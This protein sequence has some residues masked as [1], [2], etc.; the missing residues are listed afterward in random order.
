[1]SG[2]GHVTGELRSPLAG[3][4]AGGGD[5]AS[6]PL[7]V[8]GPFLVLL[9]G[10]GVA[11]ETFG[12]SIWLAVLT[13]VV[14]ST[15][16]RLVMRWVTDGSGGTGLTEDEFGG[17]AART[18][19]AIT[20]IEFSL[21]FAVSVAALVTVL[22]DRLPAMRSDLAGIELRLVAALAISVLCGFLVNRG[23]RTVG[24][25]FGPAT[26][27]VLVLL[28]LMVAATLVRDGFRP[29]SLHLSAFR[30]DDLGF[31][32]GGYVRILAVMTGVEVFANLV[33]AYSGPAPERS[34]KAFQSLLI[35]MGTT[36]VAMVIVGPAI[37]AVA[38]PLDAEVSVFTQTM[39]VLLPA[40]LA[41]AGSVAGVAVL[42]SAA[43]AS[44]L[45][46]QNLAGGLVRRR[47]L[48]EAFGRTNHR[49]VA[50]LP[51]WTE[52]GVVAACFV[53]LGTEEATFL[54]VYAAGVFVLLSMTGWAAATR[55]VRHRRAG[56]GR[57]GWGLASCLVAAVLTSTATVVIFYE[58][59]GDGVWIYFVLVPV[60]YAAFGLVRRWRGAPDLVA[61]RLGRIQANAASVAGWEKDLVDPARRLDPATTAAVDALASGPD[62][63]GESTAAGRPLVPGQ[64]VSGHVPGRPLASGTSPVSLYVP[65]GLRPGPRRALLVP[66]DGSANSERAVPSAVGLAEAGR[67]VVLLHAL[68]EEL[69]EEQA[70]AYLAAVVAVLAGHGVE[71]TVQLEEGPPAEV[72]LARAERHDGVLVVMGSHGH[73][74]IR[75]AVVGSVTE[76]VLAR[77]GVPV[78]VVAP[79]APSAGS[80]PPG[81]R[82][83]RTSRS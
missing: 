48:P 80:A 37:L 81:R 36:A 35:I 25:V 66:L 41:V 5:P 30:G 6:S 18:N 10:T 77:A 38:D 7:Y 43:A 56:L 16:Y 46:L 26:G 8:F 11:P 70:S 62:P 27:A 59:L 45:G 42:L 24:A 34:R 72:I 61:E 31:T 20:V 3:A 53:L 71:A 79:S 12:A 2:A 69:P 47:Y 55:L 44:A 33:A 73:T 13:I 83:S 28:W 49:G 4:L 14:V 57:D 17:W 65:P 82:V 22:A 50:G 74:G 21:T 58:R 39:D 51:V 32:V 60:L 52:V 67:T 19:A 15:M 54:G 1:M 40:P 9:A 76:L 29:A 64:R 75:R 78:L 68:H 23:P 63:E